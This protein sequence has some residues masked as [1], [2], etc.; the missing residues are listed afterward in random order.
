MNAIR[1]AWKLMSPADRLAVGYLIVAAVLLFVRAGAGTDYLV[2]AL[3]VVAGVVLIS[4]TALYPP[5]GPVLRFVRALYPL[6]FISIAYIHVGPFAHMIYGEGVSFDPLVAEWDRLLFGSNPHLWF[7]QLAPGRVIA[8]L[9]HLLYSLYF[10]LLFA[11]VLFVWVRRREEYPRY[12]FVFIG[13]F[14]TFVI[15]FALL[16]ATGPLE[17]R[18]GLFDGVIMSRFVDFLFSFGIPSV[19]GAFPSSHVGQSIVVLLLLRPLRRGP[20][21][22]IVSVIAGIS[23]SM[24]YGAI[25]Y[26]VDAVA[27]IP[28]GIVLYYAWDRIYRGIVTSD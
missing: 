20:A 23:V 14:I 18:A 1:N 25:H 6:A 4:G 5:R 15:A 9:M 3:V 17:F 7:F 10:P 19:G 28:S 13:S 2:Q 21:L 11:G 16:P 24:V 8:E 12:A 26:A 27:G 22:L